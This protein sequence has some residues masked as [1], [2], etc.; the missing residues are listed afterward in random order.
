MIA[1]RAFAASSSLLP[2]FCAVDLMLERSRSVSKA[3]GWILLMVTF[4]SATVRATPARKAVRPARAPEDKSSPASGAFTEDE[5]MLM[6]RPKPRCA[7]GSITFWINS[8]ATTTWAMTPSIIA[9]RVSSRKSLN[10]GPALLL[11]KMSGAG[12][13]ASSA[14]WPS[15]V[16]TSATTGIILAPAVAESSAAVAAVD[17][18]LAA[19]LRQR[20]GASLAEPAARGTDNGLAAGDT[21]IHGVPRTLTVGALVVQG[22]AERQGEPGTVRPRGPP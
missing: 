13:A 9:C 10:G 16:A 21:E 2:V 7:I 11:T 19:G 3:P 4:L 5:V 17:H 22:G 18:H 8:T 1:M 14:F 12:Q 20:L 15:A 6:M